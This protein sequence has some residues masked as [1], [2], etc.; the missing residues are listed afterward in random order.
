MNV[1]FCSMQSINLN[2]LEEWYADNDDY[3][4]SYYTIMKNTTYTDYY[5]A[6]QN[7]KMTCIPF[8]IPEN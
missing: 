1:Y 6:G 3:V 5:G 8:L 7:A 4:D 2:K